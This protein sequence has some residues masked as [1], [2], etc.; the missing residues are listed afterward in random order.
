MN[1]EKAFSPVQM[2]IQASA[3]VPRSRGASPK[4]VIASAGGKRM[5]LP[6]RRVAVDPIPQAEPEEVKPPKPRFMK[7][8]PRA[9]K[10]DKYSL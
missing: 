3:P 7:K 6:P 10:V 4:R 5:E 1:S 8:K 9:L 2:P